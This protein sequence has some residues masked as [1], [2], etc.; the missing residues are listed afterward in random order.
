MKTFLGYV[1][2]GHELMNSAVAEI[3][4]VVIRHRNFN[5]VLGQPAKDAKY[6]RYS[7]M[8]QLLLHVRFR[9]AVV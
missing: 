6:N 9:S 4:V 8:L 5:T 7:E 1:V 2:S 3:E